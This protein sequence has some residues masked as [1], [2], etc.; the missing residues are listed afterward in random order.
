M[1]FSPT[2]S[3]EPFLIYLNY[4]SLFKVLKL[5]NDH[6]TILSGIRVGTDRP[7]HDLRHWHSAVPQEQ[8]RARAFRRSDDHWNA[9]R[10]LRDAGAL[11]VSGETGS[12][13]HWHPMINDDANPAGPGAAARAVASL[14]CGWPGGGRS[15]RA[16]G[17]A[18]ARP[19]ATAS[20][21]GAGGAHMGRQTHAFHVGQVWLGKAGVS[22]SRG[23]HSACSPRRDRGAPLVKFCSGLPFKLCWTGSTAPAAPPP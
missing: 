6:V 20:A 8:G 2:Q 19:A 5:L 1:R 21:A 23:R 15:Q 9:R 4:E 12:P 11:P 18:R 16:D 10:E 13:S 22:L 17:T 7:V 3:I 14:S